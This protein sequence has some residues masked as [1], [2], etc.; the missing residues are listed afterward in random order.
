M[1]R[2]S[3]GVGLC[4]HAGVVPMTG[5]CWDLLK[6][7]DSEGRKGAAVGTRKREKSARGR[8]LYKQAP[9]DYPALTG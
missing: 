9:F 5:R 7:Q 2:S 1:A 3:A 8:Q 6:R 4:V